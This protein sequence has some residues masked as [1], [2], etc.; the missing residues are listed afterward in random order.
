[1]ED[2][3]KYMKF[4]EKEYEDHWFQKYPELE[5]DEQNKPN[6]EDYFKASERVKF[7]RQGGKGALYGPKGVQGDGM[8][9]KEYYKITD[10]RNLIDRYKDS[11]QLLK[12]KASEYQTT[13][14]INKDLTENFETI[15]QLTL[16][17]KPSQKSPSKPSL[18]SRN[19]LSLKNKITHK[20]GEAIK[21][22]TKTKN[23]K[24]FRL[25]ENFREDPL[26]VK[27]SSEKA[28]KAAGPARPLYQGFMANRL[29]RRHLSTANQGFRTS[30]RSLRS[31]LG[32]TSPSVGNK[33]PGSQ[34]NFAEIPIVTKFEP[35][36]H[37]IGDLMG[38]P[39]RVLTSR[40]KNRI[41]QSRNTL[42]RKTDRGKNKKFFETLRSN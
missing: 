33:A 12:G 40:G 22:L 25:N 3:K 9:L 31:T 1:M 11:P 41:T 39:S 7:W 16:S 36:E 38:S 26:L 18:R 6:L 10:D 19:R 17:S 4:S 28:K 20:T 8:S 32:S 42:S 35:F 34:R 2:A 29:G 24:K 23:T 37:A 27:N 21:L 13:T 30:R 14:K 5:E 15:S